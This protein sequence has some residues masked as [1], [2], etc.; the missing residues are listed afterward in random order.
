MTKL[1][2]DGHTARCILF[3]ATLLITMGAGA[4]LRADFIL[5]RSGGC[6]PLTVSFTNRTT[7]A[8]ASAQ[9]RWDL[10]NG[11][12]SVL[13]NPGA[14][15]R[16]EKTY[17]VTLTVTDGSQ[18]SS[19]TATVTVYKKPEADFTVGLP[20]VCMPASASFTSTA[21]AGDGFINSYQWDFGD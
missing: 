17:T 21:T 4:Q 12:T 19:K 14:V 16:E 10:G 3:L 1:T 8:S 6:S 15:Y 18:V 2:A 7:G 13:Q 20:K 9:Y 11:N 5:D